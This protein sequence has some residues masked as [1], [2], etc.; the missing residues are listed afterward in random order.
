MRKEGYSIYHMSTALKKNKI[1]II[2]AIEHMARAGIVE[3]LEVVGR[4]L[5]SS[6]N[7][8]SQSI[9]NFYS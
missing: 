5:T 6:T 8:V 3:P 2:K 7:L 9:D 4:S 1:T